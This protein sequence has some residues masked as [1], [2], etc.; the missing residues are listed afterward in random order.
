MTAQRQIE[1]VIFDCDGVLVDSEVLALEVERA[2]LGEVGLVY[3][4]DEHLRRFHGLSIRAFYDALA[5]DAIARTGKPLP[6][7]FEARFDAKLRDIYDTRLEAID[8]VADLVRAIDLPKAV[9][10]SSRMSF[11]QRKLE[12][13][14]V[15]AFFEPH[16]YSADDVARGKPAPD[17]FLLAA[18][19]IGADPATTLVVEDSANGI[20]AAKAAGMIAAGFTGGGHCGPDHADMLKAAGAEIVFASCAEI[21]DHLGLAGRWPM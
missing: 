12:R 18:A 9:A 8:G 17:L 14:K 5:A 4:A 7:D 19:R 2:M 21:A 15:K 3:T 10:S 1:S 6:R 13:A 11:L 16:I 20:L